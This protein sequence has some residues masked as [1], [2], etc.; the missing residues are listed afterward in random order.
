VVCVYAVRPADLN[1]RRCIIVCICFDPHVR[2]PNFEI[3]DVAFRRK[4]VVMLRSSRL[5]LR[6]FW[7]ADLQFWKHSASSI[8][9]KVP[10]RRWCPSVTAWHNIP[11]ILMSQLCLF[12][13]VS[14]FISRCFALNMLYI[15]ECYNNRKLQNAKV[16]Q[17]RDHDV[18]QGQ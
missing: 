2:K 3:L 17:G 14:S 10:L 12:S 1:A 6:A 9:Q 18:L 5:W 8:T 11:V 7:Y 16:V 15:M 13:I 4:S